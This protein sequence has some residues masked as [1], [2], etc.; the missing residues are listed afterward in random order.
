V[1]WSAG[2]GRWL[3]G[4]LDLRVT[5]AQPTAFLG[6]LLEAGVPFR[7]ARGVGDGLRLRIALR[8]FRRVRPAASGSGARVR[9]AARLGAPFLVARLARRPFLV[10][11]TVVAALA[12]Y[13]LSGF[14]WFVEVQ[15]TDRVAPAVVL[16]AA[17]S[18][19]LRPGVWRGGLDAATLA[20]R[21]PVVVGDLSWAAVTLHGTLAIIAVVERIRP[22][23]AYAEAMFKGDVVAAHDGIVTAITVHAGQAEVAPGATV[24]TG[25]VLIRGWAALPATRSHAGA[26]QQTT[27]HASGTVLARQ[28]YSTYAE[29]PLSLSVGIPT[30]RA[31]VRRSVLVGSVRLDLQGWG[32][33]PFA[34][35]ALRRDVGSPLHWRNL[36]LPVE[37]ATLRYTEVKYYLRRLSV[38]DAGDLAA[39]EAR[40]FLIPHLP[41]HARI[42]Q[43]RRRTF[44]LPGGD[45]AG[46][47]L[48][49]ETEDMICV[50]R[51]AAPEAGP[52][53]PAPAGTGA[54]GMG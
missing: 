1:P 11:A 9:I 8:H 13:V 23:P 26:L 41:P 6:L 16:G 28:W 27:V 18:L 46:V 54:G 53:I 42:L 29:V 10:G 51:A 50:F 7:R 43:E 45:R 34:A 5:V 30:G 36:T 3:R 25:Q 22:R 17:A 52:G 19:G 14:V 49:V 24:H 12:L 4:E 38:D 48:Q 37:F 21:L 2:L 44:A 32:R 31:F 47:E 33:V 40:T 39:A 15:G 35:Y 20:R